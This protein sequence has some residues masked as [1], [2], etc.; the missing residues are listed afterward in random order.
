MS[1][2]TPTLEPY[3]CPHTWARVALTVLLGE[4]G[5]QYAS[6]LR[7]RLT[8]HALRPKSIMIKLSLEIITV[9]IIAQER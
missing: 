4:Q 7:R 1:H 6:P 8:A 2:T 5:R 3:T 9:L